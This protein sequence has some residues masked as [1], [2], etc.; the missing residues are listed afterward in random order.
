MDSG[1]EFVGRLQET[2]VG[3]PGKVSLVSKKDQEK[4]KAR[5]EDG[6]NQEER[7]NR[8]QEREYG[9]ARGNAGASADDGGSHAAQDVLLVETSAKTPVEEASGVGP[10]K[11]IADNTL[12]L[13]AASTIVE[14]RPP[15]MLH[16]APRVLKRF[17]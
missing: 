8:L 14:I 16:R 4:M 11:N 3:K 13:H 6:L 7:V 10:L 2:D 12:S 15:Y 5:T 1:E 17:Q 9:I